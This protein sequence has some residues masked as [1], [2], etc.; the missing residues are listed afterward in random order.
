MNI[1]KVAIIDYDLKWIKLITDLINKEEDMAVIWNAS[2]KEAALSHA[3]SKDIDIILMNNKL[4]E[5]GQDID[6]LKTFKEIAHLSQAKVI[7][8]TSLY[9]EALIK[10][11]F[12]DG[13]VNYVLKNDNTN[14]PAL[15]RSTYDHIFSPLEV[16]FKDYYQV[17]KE[18]QLSPLTTTE[19]E[20]YLLKQQGF[21]TTQI[22]DKTNKDNGTIRNQLSKAYKKLKANQ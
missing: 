3:G 7:M 2:N 19:K 21:T 10:N 18:L 15:V 11:S 16:I 22:A 12:F 9:N 14:F 1:I 6:N 8:M 5:D 17:K 4:D 13:V 20:I